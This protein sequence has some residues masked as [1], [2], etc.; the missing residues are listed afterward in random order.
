[1]WVIVASWCL[2]TTG[3]TSCSVTADGS[4]GLSATTLPHLDQLMSSAEVDAADAACVV[5][6]VLIHGFRSARRLAARPDE[7]DHRR[8][9][10]FQP[11]ATGTFDVEPR[12]LGPIHPVPAVLAGAPLLDSAGRP[13]LVIDDDATIVVTHSEKE[14]TAATFSIHARRSAQS[15]T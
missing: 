14:R 11:A 1:V 10:A 3:S 5:A 12:S 13:V 15:P 9:V 4:R 8:Q 7:F 6:G 2:A